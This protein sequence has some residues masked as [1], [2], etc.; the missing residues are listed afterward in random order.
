MPSNLH[1][2]TLLAYP[3]PGPGKRGSRIL[4]AGMAFV[5]SNRLESVFNKWKDT[6]SEQELAEIMESL[7]ADHGD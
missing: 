1:G 5:T 3:P 2:T 6:L 4:Q 7:V